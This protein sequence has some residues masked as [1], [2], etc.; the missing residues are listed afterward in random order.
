MFFEIMGNR[1]YTYEPCYFG[2][3][4]SVRYYLKCTNKKGCTF[5]GC[6]LSFI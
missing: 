6:S 4:L 2:L 3:L 5:G 1:I